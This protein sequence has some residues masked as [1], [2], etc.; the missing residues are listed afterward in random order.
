M[1]GTFGRSRMAVA[2]PGMPMPTSSK[3]VTTPA[4]GVTLA[5]PPRAETSHDGHDQ[6]ADKP[7]YQKADVEQ[8]RV[9]YP[10]SRF[11]GVRCLVPHRKAPLRS[12]AEWS[13]PKGVIG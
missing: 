13:T 4:H 11:N 8:V 2:M 9:Y 12:K 3:A 7:E 10:R 5:V 1:T 6:D